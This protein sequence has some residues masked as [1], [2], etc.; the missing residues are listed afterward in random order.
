MTETSREVP[1]Y[2]SGGA[3]KHSYSTEV[4]KQWPLFAIEMAR[5][6][7]ESRVLLIA[8]AFS[9]PTGN[10]FRQVFARL[11]RVAFHVGRFPFE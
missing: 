8:V 2:K 1:L 9:P 5:F 6:I 3:V 4:L 10:G 7:N 11:D